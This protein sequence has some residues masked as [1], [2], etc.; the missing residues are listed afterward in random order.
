MLSFGFVKL[1]V[2]VRNPSR[3]VVG[4][5]GVQGRGPG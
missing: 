2:P 1:A 3:G 4:L 5:T